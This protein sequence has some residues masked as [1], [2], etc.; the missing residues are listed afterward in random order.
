MPGTNF[1]DLED[2]EVG[3][4]PA[5][6]LGAPMLEQEKS[7]PSQP[8]FQEEFGIEPKWAV[9]FLILI[10]FILFA[11]IIWLGVTKPSV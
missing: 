10:V 9:L 5:L 11:I 8:T 7:R 1:E 3:I 4:M 2:L 6:E